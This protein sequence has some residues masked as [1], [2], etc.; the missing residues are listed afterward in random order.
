LEKYELDKIERKKL[1]KIFDSFFCSEFFS[2]KLSFLLRIESEIRLILL[3]KKLDVE[4]KR[5][6]ELDENIL[7]LFLR[8]LARTQNDFKNK[9]K[10]IAI[11]LDWVGSQ[12]LQ[13]SKFYEDSKIK[14][15]QLW[16]VKK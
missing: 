14:G 5:E 4:G 1:G 11:V 9:L 10:E 7:A 2:E 15:L 12:S 6:G 8:N 13:S 3:M 16:K